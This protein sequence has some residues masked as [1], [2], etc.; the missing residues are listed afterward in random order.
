[1]MNF[2]TKVC[3]KLL[4]VTSGV[5]LFSG[6]NRA[7]EATL[8]ETSIYETI[9]EV[10][11]TKE[12]T[13]EDGKYQVSETYNTI[14]EYD[15]L[16]FDLVQYS[17]SEEEQVIEDMEAHLQQMEKYVKRSERALEELAKYDYEE[18]N[19]CRE[20]LILYRDKALA[21]GE[22]VLNDLPEENDDKY[23]WDDYDANVY[24]YCELARDD[25]FYLWDAY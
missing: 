9:E 13:Y 2:Y 19:E 4:V 10:Q 5:F 8:P 15:S 6:C 1:M 20:T 12:Y 17:S 25:V 14:H 11:E 21:Y 18:I 22:K 16:L 23:T 7:E 3:V 24:K